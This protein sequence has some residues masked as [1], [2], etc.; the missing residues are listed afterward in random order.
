MKMQGPA[1][2]P[3]ILL[4]GAHGQLGHALHTALAALGQVT[5][6]DRDAADLARPDTLRDRLL[7]IVAALRPT[8]WVNAA[9]YTAV[10][11]AQVEPDV[12]HAVNATSPGILAELAEA[13]D[14][15][16][17]HYSSD[18]VFDGSGD[19]PWRESDAPCPLAVYGQTKLAGERAVSSRCR[20]HLI[21]RTSWVVGPHGDN[22][23]KTILRRGA[24]RDTLRVVD[25]QIGAP[26][27]TGLLAAVTVALLRAMSGATPTDPRWGCYHVAPAGFTSWHG[28][29]QYVVRRAHERGTTLA[30]TADHVSPIPSSQYPLPAPRPLN[31]RLD[32]S[33]L[34][35]TFGVELPDWRSGVDDVLQQLDAKAAT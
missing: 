10:D 3:R 32:T 5:A 12:T 16:L 20:R 35:T 15:T 25:D 7:P 21:L 28:V 24:E 19:A 22:F 34:R 13:S 11:R 26:T 14:A 6:L 31:S 4:F 27:S 29:A 18:Y 30:L 1:E 23:V 2:S 9:A 8:V 17:V 33:K